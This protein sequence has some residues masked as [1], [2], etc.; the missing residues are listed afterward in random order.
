MNKWSYYRVVGNVILDPRVYY[1]VASNVIIGVRV[2]CHVA[3]TRARNDWIYQ[4]VASNMVLD[5]WIYRDEFLQ[6]LATYIVQ[7]EFCPV[8]KIVVGISVCF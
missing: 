5:P 2:Y 1:H 6:K 7:C 8:G 4:H 3:I